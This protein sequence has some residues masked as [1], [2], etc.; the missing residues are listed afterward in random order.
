MNTILLDKSNNPLIHPNSNGL[1]TFTMSVDINNGYIHSV[2]QLVRLRL[3]SVKRE[4]RFQPEGVIDWIIMMN[5]KQSRSVLGSK[6][7]SIISQTDGV[8]S[9]DLSKSKY[10]LDNTISLVGVCFTIGCENIEVNI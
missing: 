8:D 6:V 1:S 4:T 7:F 2:G 9:V 3:M 5:N 10:D